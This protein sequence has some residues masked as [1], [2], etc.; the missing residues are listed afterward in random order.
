MTA[1]SSIPPI[2]LAAVLV[3]GCGGLDETRGAVAGGE[4]RVVDRQ[5]GHRDGAANDAPGTE[6]GSADAGGDASG[7]G[8]V[9]AWFAVCDQCAQQSCNESDPDSVFPPFY[10]TCFPPRTA[11]HK[12]KTGP[13]QGQYV[14]DLCQ[15][16]LDCVRLSGCY[17][18]DRFGDY[19]CYCGSS[20]GTADCLVDG[21]A[22]GPCREA[23]EN[24]AETTS[25]STIV[26]G[27]NDPV[28]G[29]AAGA[30]NALLSQ[31]EL[32]PFPN[33]TPVPCASS[34][35]PTDP[36]DAGP[37]A[38]HPGTAGT[39]G[40]AG[41]SGGSGGDSGGAGGAASDGCTVVTTVSDAC[42]TCETVGNPL[43][44]DAPGMGTPCDPIS[45]TA[46]STTDE[47]GNPVAVGWGPT[48]FA[49]SS[50]AQQEATTELMRKVVQLLPGS[51]RTNANDANYVVDA[52]GS[53]PNIANGLL[54]LGTSSDSLLYHT[55]N[56]ATSGT[57]LDE[58]RA[59]ALADAAGNL[60]P[61][62]LTAT[63]AANLGKLANYISTF[64][65]NPTSAIGLADNV[66]TCALATPCP[67]C[68]D[69]Q[70]SFTTTTVCPPHDGGA[71]DAAD[72]GRETSGTG[73][74]GAAGAAGSAGA[75]G[76]AGGTGSAGG[77]GTGGTGNGG[78]GGSHLPS[79]PDLDG[80]GLGDCQ[81][82][83][84][85]NAG[86]DHATTGWSEERGATLAWISMDAQGKSASGALSVVNVDNAAA[87]GN[88]LYAASGT[89]V[90]G[91]SQ[92]LPVPASA[93]YEVAV[94]AFV[95]PWQGVGAAS[96]VV[97]SY[98]SPDCAAGSLWPKPFLGAEVT[99]AGA[100]QPIVGAAVIGGGIQ[101]IAVRLVAE[102]PV[103]QPPTSFQVLFDDVLVRVKAP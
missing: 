6:T 42:K 54:V 87:D 5:G 68:L 92:C 65:G 78:A 84:V 102:K 66:L 18:P 35:V 30:A 76:A 9:P 2:V 99:A 64:A 96:L 83:L 81:Q 29:K 58:Y 97:D 73:G 15:A 98:F 101:S 86:F 27:Q 53:T 49:D 60:G 46:T 90:A 12:A 51:A 80:D 8:G 94:Q 74:V 91:A 48:S 95:P 19:R 62:G 28:V 100:W 75:A 1:P 21:K 26:S 93:T 59:A 88:T 103:T 13:A 69:A 63:Q 17:E 3:A 43:A 10:D 85:A 39:G 7:T 72:A 32:G 47:D 61:S 41:S 14:A 70:T 36:P 56:I 38:G 16:V 50:L 24:A 67:A 82:T 11:D 25:A 44:G 40:A 55:E 71:A 31:C 34:C 22:D 57:A 37:E 23:I 45:L 77:G 33:G 89:V 20:A 4:G 79:C 52:S